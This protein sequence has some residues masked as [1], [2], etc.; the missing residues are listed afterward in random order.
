MQEQQQK[1]KPSTPAKSKVPVAATPKNH[2]TH[3]VP[4]STSTKAGGER[5]VQNGSGTTEDGG[6]G[7]DAESSSLLSKSAP[8]S[9]SKKKKPK[10]KKKA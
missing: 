2:Q 5:M 8:T 1:S 6:S 4:G 7:S 9:A 10:R 3:S